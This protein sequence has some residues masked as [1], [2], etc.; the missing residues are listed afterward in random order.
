MERCLLCHLGQT[1]APDALGVLAKWAAPEPCLSPCSGS[2]LLQHGHAVLRPWGQPCC[3]TTEPFW[4]LPSLCP[5]EWSCHSWSHMPGVHS[6]YSKAWMDLRSHHWGGFCPLQLWSS[7][8]AWCQRHGP[9]HAVNGDC[10]GKD[11]AW[12]QHC[13]PRQ[14][15]SLWDRDIH[16]CEWCL[17]IPMVH[18]GNPWLWVSPK[19]WPQGARR[20]M[21]ASTS[22]LA[23]AALGTTGAGALVLH[24]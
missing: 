5:V 2:A 19:A 7:I 4:P 3:Q 13:Q 23:G 16:T 17:W 22:P 6:G 9:Q 1:L 8:T 10:E 18:S 21:A 11:T 24:P 20:R 15:R 14:S 12:C